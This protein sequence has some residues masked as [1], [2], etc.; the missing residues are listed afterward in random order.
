MKGIKIRGSIRGG[1]DGGGA[2]GDDDDCYTKFVPLV[3][4]KIM[5][6]TESTHTKIFHYH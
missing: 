1:G 4:S 6:K 3:R 2:E 5:Y